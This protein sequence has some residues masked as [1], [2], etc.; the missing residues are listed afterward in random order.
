MGLKLYRCADA[1][2]GGG[3]AI[4]IFERKYAVDD[5]RV[6]PGYILIVLPTPRMV[7]GSCTSPDMAEPAPQGWE[8]GSQ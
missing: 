1:D 6:D 7:T 4:L 5:R 2:S 3:V 8:T